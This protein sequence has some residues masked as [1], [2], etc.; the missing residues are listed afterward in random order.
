[1]VVGL[2]AQEMEPLAA[3]AAAVWLHGAAA[4]R[5]GPGLVSEDL[6]DAA[7][8]AKRD[9]LCRQNALSVQS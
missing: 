1:M 9:L 3:A 5:V 8:V 6:V 4:S 7:A 2:L